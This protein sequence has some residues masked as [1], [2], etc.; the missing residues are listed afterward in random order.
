MY[1]KSMLCAVIALIGLGSSAGAQESSS[2]P[3]GAPSITF[4]HLPGADDMPAAV[5]SPHATDRYLFVPAAAFV[6]RSNAD[7]LVNTGNGCIYTN[8][9]VLN[10]D[11]QLPAG[12]LV[13]GVRVYYHVPGA[14]GSV[15]TW[16][17][18]YDG[19][20]TFADLMGPVTTNTGGYYSQYFA[21]TPE[22]TIDPFTYSYALNPHMEGTDVKVCGVRVFYGY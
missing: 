14:T 17:T 10:A 2:G 5:T 16:L 19:A 15:T 7:S 20:G 11:L 13:H 3:H 8:G 12:A 1:S 9:W 21:L 4:Q 6:R 22:E 18:R